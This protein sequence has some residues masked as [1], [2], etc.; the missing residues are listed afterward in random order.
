MRF[1]NCLVVAVLLLA[2]CSGPSF[3]WS[4]HWKGR[5]DLKAKPGENEAVLNSIAKID[6]KLDP[7]GTFE[8]LEGGAPK[9]GDYRTEGTSA[10]LKVKTFFGRPIEAQG[11]VAVKLNQEILLKAQKDGTIVFSDPAGFTE[12][13]IV[14]TRQKAESQPAP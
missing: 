10:I 12:E 9:E 2:G 14:L 6:L 8:L 11:E 1:V 3:Q 4:G 5:R 13:S 7:N